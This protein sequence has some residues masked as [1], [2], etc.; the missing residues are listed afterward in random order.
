MKNY[1][2]N[3]DDFP[4]SWLEEVLGGNNDHTF[5]HAAFADTWCNVV[6]ETS[7]F[8]PYASEKIWKPIASGQI[9]LAVAHPF[10]LD[11]LKSFGFHVF[12]EQYDVELDLL[13]R[14]TMVV[15]T[16]KKHSED[17]QQ[18]WIENKFLIEHNYHLF[19][20]GNVERQILD[21]LVSLLNGQRS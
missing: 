20:S 11:W 16:I 21:P 7:V 1:T 9:F 18:W 6:T 19:H 12:D 14:I 8:C 2:T 4:L 10:M 15:D 5:T 13:K 17:P 3:V